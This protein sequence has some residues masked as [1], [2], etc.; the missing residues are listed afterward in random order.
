MLWGS[1]VIFPIA[2]LI[3]KFRNEDVILKSNPFGLLM[4]RCVL[5]VNLLWAVHIPL[6]LKVPEYVPLTLGIGLGLH[7]L[8]YSW[9]IKHPV[10]T[11]NSILRTVSILVVW[12]LFPEHRIVAT[13][14]TIVAIYILSLFQM[15]FREVNLG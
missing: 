5:M 4:G 15:Q 7:W 10:G 11:I 14:F 3:A 1:G 12:Y 9:I 2:L 8:V 6:I 13:A